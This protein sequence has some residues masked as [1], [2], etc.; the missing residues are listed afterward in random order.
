M[1]AMRSWSFGDSLSAWLPNNRFV[2]LLKLK[3]RKILDTTFFR[4]SNI[5][6]TS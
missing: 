2:G 1:N 6:T 3:V 5:S 4:F